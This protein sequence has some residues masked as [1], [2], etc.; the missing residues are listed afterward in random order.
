MRRTALLLFGIAA[1]CSTAG[2]R[3]TA[4]I[5]P[6]EAQVRGAPLDDGDGGPSDPAASWGAS[7]LS[8]ATTY[9][10]IFQK[11]GLDCFDRRYAATLADAL[12]ETDAIEIDI[13]DGAGLFSSG[14]EPGRWYVRRGRTGGDSSNARA[15]GDLE[16]C[17]RDVAEWLDRRDWAFDGSRPL[18]LTIFIDKRQGWSEGRRPADLDELIARTVPA[19][20]IFTPVELLDSHESLRSA[21]SYSAWPSLAALLESVGR[22]V[23]VLAGENEVL[24][25]YVTERGG[26]A[27]CFVAARTDDPADVLGAPD[28]FEGRAAGWVVFHD[29]RPGDE[30]LAPLVRRQGRLSRVSGAPADDT[31]YARLVGLGV[32][33]IA[34][35]RFQERSLN[36]GLMNGELRPARFAHHAHHHH[37]ADARCVHGLRATDDEQGH[38]HHPARPSDCGHGREA[39]DD[40]A[41]HHHHDLGTGACEHGRPATDERT[42]RKLNG[43]ALPAAG[44]SHHHHERPGRCAHGR[45][46]TS[47]ANRH[48]HHE[49]GE[50]RGHGVPATDDAAG[51]HHHEW[52]DDCEHGVWATSEPMR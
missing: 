50:E 3:R 2:E 31:T 13:W 34:L 36:G 33:F 17:L 18:V 4:D 42:F 26:R 10:R 19:R 27:A 47:E 28:G 41:A 23:F 22:V 16:A 1:A 24:S 52:D 32:N 35:R 8:L 12:A 7:R 14:A 40:V 15:P 9:D 11:A 39:T 29:L 51:H 25:E 49:R 21:A 38:H 20:W 5:V 48:H 45:R 46:A 44:E 37:E 43:A 30:R 6:Q